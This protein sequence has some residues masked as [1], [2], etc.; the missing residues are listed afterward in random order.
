M[1][2]DSK[3]DSGNLA[4]AEYDG[5]NRVKFHNFVMLNRFISKL[6]QIALEQKVKNS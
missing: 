6:V 2:I 5:E 1:S 3:F 4:Y